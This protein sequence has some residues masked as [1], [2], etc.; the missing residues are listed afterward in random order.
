MY[1]DNSLFCAAGMLISVG[2]HGRCS[3][4]ASGGRA[5]RIQTFSGEKMRKPEACGKLLRVAEQNFPQ[6][7][8]F[9]GEVADTVY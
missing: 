9:F 8:F 5:F 7:V 4:G 6:V 1:I 3:L 2:V